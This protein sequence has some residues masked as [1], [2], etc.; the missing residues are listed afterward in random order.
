MHSTNQSTLGFPVKLAYSAPVFP[1]SML[2]VPALSMLPALYAKHGNV[3]LAVI[4]TILVLTRLLDAFTDPLI[5]FLSDGTESRLGA[6]KPWIILGTVM[7]CIGVYFWFRPGESTDWVYFLVWSVVVY[8]GWT[9]IEIPHTAWLAELTRD[10]DERSSLSSYRSVAAFLGYAVFLSLPMWPIFPT[11]EMTPDVTAAAS[12]FI[13]ILLPILALITILYVPE[14]E[15]IRQSKPEVIET[16]KATVTNI[17]LALYI[18]SALTANLASGMV[19]GLYFF[20]LDNY[21]NILDK[22][23]HIGLIVAGCSIVASLL[24]TP[25]ISRL[26]KHRVMA[27]AAAINVLVL[28]GMALLRPG[29]FAFP[30]LLLLFSMSA[31]LN[32]FGMIAAYALLADIIDFEK[33]RS[34]RNRAG[35]FYAF[36]A[37][38]MKSGI[39][40]GGGLGLLIVSAFGF[41]PN[42]DNNQLAMTGFFISFIGVPI[43]LYIAAAV[44][45]WLAP[46][47]RRGHAIIEKRLNLLEAR[48][49]LNTR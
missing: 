23:G 1:I 16:L 20:Y 6:R 5:G 12:W 14:G 26:G 38:I 27:G 9:L 35:N 31:V 4:G 15:K 18:G 34:G 11:S 21:L 39:A 13:I 41:E 33:L 32:A 25:L 49:R 28:T 43:L 48:G 2:H 44:F 29:E 42:G 30:G 19:A 3:D 10:Y 17:P 22:I 36:Q 37:L 40:I 24:A 8:I 46:I 47:D 45:A 7:S